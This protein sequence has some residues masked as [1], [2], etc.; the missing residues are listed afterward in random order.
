MKEIIIPISDLKIGDQVKGSDDKWYTISEILPSRIPNRMFRLEFSNGCVECS[1]DHQWTYVDHNGIKRITDTLGI[2][3]SR[4]LFTELDF[5]FGKED[6]PILFN[7]EEIEPK[8][9]VCIKL[10]NKDHLYEIFTDKGSPILTHNCGFRMVCGRLGGVA[11]LMALGNSMATAIDGKHPGAGMIS[12]QGV[13][14]NIQ[15]YYEE[16][17]WLEKWFATRGLNKLGYLEN[18]D[19]ETD[20]EEQVLESLEGEE[21]LESS[22]EVMNIE[23]AGIKGQVDKKKDQHFEEV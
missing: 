5:H 7:I 11:S 17:A 19:E 1:D 23:F 16:H 15:Y 21:N 20:K 18:A 6:G 2:F 9:A 13:I 8:E 12:S 22:S 3:E 4:K 10:N 14:D